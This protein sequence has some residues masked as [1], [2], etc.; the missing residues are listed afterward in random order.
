MLGI[1]PRLAYSTWWCECGWSVLGPVYSPI[2]F[3]IWYRKPVNLRP[4]IHGVTTIHI[5]LISRW[6]LRWSRAHCWTYSSVTHQIHIGWMQ[7]STVSAHIKTSKQALLILVW[8]KLPI[9]KAHIDVSLVL[10][11]S[12][13]AIMKH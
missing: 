4:R 3:V 2:Y 5:F 13:N 1:R 8:N 9:V 7:L 10:H 6:L 12:T 11:C